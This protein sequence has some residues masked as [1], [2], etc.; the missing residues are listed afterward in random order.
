MSEKSKP[1]SVR[2]S[3]NWKVSEKD[4]TLKCQKLKVSEK[5]EKTESVGN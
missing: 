1:E 5:E 4:E 3:Q 2:K